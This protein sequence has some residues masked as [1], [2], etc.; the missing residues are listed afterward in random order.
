MY[1]DVAQWKSGTLEIEGS[2][3]RRNLSK[4]TVIVAVVLRINTVEQNIA[5]KSAEMLHQE[6]PL[7]LVFSYTYF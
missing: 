1:T 2:L 3:A 4:L 6:L 7:I 5:F